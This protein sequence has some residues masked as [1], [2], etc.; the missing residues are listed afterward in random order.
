MGLCFE[1]LPQK[2]PGA[3]WYAGG[4]RAGPLSVNTMLPVSRAAPTAAQVHPCAS[5]NAEHAK[6]AARP[7][8]S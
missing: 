1:H 6:N 8:F 7:F 4:Q 3:R 2:E 5:G